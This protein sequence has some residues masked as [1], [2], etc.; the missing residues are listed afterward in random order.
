M[1]VLLL[2]LAGCEG[3]TRLY[4]DLTADELTLVRRLSALSHE[5]STCVCQPTMSV[6]PG[7]DLCTCGHLR[8][9]H[10]T[11]EHGQP[12]ACRHHDADEGCCPRFEGADCVH[13]HW[14]RATHRGDCCCDEPVEAHRVCCPLGQRLKY[15]D[16]HEEID[17][18]WQRRDGGACPDSCACRQE[19]P[20]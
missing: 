11:T 4:V 17:G 13:G 2:T 14:L 15:L 7:P 12:D 18:Q 10:S 20:F 6:S 5:V 16:T 8:V 19:V 1:S 3:S 9:E